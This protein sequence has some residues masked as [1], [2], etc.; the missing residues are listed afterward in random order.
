VRGLQLVLLAAL[1]GCLGFG[2]DPAAF[3]SCGNGIVDRDEEC[4]DGNSASG[5]GCSRACTLELAGCGDNT[6]DPGEECDDGNLTDGDGCSATCRIESPRR[7]ILRQTSTDAI[8]ASHSASCRDTG[9][10]ATYQNS[11]YRRFALA[12]HAITDKLAIEEVSLG[13]DEAV[14]GGG[15]T[16]QPIVL[17]IHDY[18]GPAAGTS[19]D[20]ALMTELASTTISVPSSAGILLTT[21]IAVELDAGSRFVVEVFVPDGQVSGN[22]FRLGANAS[23]ETQPAFLL[24]PTCS[25]SVPT[26]IPSIVT[27]RMVHYVLKVT[28]TVR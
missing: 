19:L 18:R 5:D 28:G 4:D 3:E 7:V 12:D 14:P 11:W 17:R 9:T 2:D 20:P 24:A 26:A 21:P 16:T 13:L 27:D 15:A 1:G 25:V 6:L 8:V 23:G 10:G 22:R